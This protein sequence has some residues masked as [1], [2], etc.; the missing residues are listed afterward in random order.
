MRKGRNLTGRFPN[1]TGFKN[2]LGLIALLLV[3]CSSVR[4]FEIETCYPAAITFPPNAGTL[5]LIDNSVQQPDNFGHH[6]I[7]SKKNDSLMRVPADSLAYD[8]CQALGRAISVSPAFDDVRICD[9]TLRHDNDFLSP[10]IFTRAQ[11]DALCD[12]YGV[13]TL[14]AINRCVCVTSFNEAQPA[15]F[16]EGD[17]ITAILNVNLSVYLPDSD[18]IIPLSLADTLMMK[19][20]FDYFETQNARRERLANLKY[21]MHYL[22][23]YMGEKAK[24][25]FIPTWNTDSRWYYT[26]YQSAW[27]RGATYIAAEKWDEAVDEFEPLLSQSSDWRLK[28]RIN[29]NLAVCHEMNGA[30]AKALEY[31][32]RAAA[33]FREHAGDDDGFTKMQKQYCY[34]LQQRLKNEEILMRQ[35]IAP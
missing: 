28:A 32:E 17:F 13:N 2:L 25:Y 23:D 11:A 26:N 19:F 22:A 21:A 10:N 18:V 8:F 34:I 4:T 27:K 6:Y 35:V 3:S 5:L 30:L 24:E 1:L 31:A 12:D 16:P 14:V 9:D 29:A 20:D 33:L 15:R 7:D